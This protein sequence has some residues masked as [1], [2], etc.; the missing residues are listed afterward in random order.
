M[1]QAQKPRVI[2]CTMRPGSRRPMG[3][4][5]TGKGDLY[6]SS[7]KWVIERLDCA[8]RNVLGNLGSSHLLP[9]D[10]DPRPKIGAAAAISP[11][12]EAEPHLE[13]DICLSSHPPTVPALRT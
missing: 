9:R 6:L 13:M 2:T 3:S 10:R 11:K 8:P 1:C 7:L 12:A 5:K 4:R